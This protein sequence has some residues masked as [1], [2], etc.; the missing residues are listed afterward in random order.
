MTMPTGPAEK[1]RREV[2]EDKDILTNNAAMT[3]NPHPL[4]AFHPH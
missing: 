1:S 3:S 2:Y 4:K